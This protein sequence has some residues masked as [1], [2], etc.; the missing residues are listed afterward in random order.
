MLP[1]KNG[2]WNFEYEFH[3]FTYK[4]TKVKTPGKKKISHCDR[5]FITNNHRHEYSQCI[6]VYFGRF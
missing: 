2:K 4:Y 5:L 1:D 3:C 6:N